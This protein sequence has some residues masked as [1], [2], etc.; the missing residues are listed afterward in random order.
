MRE[1]AETHFYDRQPDSAHTNDSKTRVFG[2]NVGCFEEC[3]ADDGLRGLGR[4]ALCHSFGLIC[5]PFETLVRQH[6][7]AG[8]IQLA[9]DIFVTSDNPGVHCDTICRAIQ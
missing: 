4:R 6:P 3:G 2:H 8:L 5:V 7:N 9:S 1:D